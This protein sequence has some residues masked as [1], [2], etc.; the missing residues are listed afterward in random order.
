MGIARDSFFRGKR[1]AW[2][3]WKGQGWALTYREDKFILAFVICFVLRRECYC[4]AA[5]RLLRRIFFTD[6]FTSVGQ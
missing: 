6:A 2:K 1:Q 3:I 5:G 4:L